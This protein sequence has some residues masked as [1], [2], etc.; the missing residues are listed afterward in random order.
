MLCSRVGSFLFS[1]T[2]QI[3]NCFGQFLAFH[4]FQQKLSD[5]FTSPL[6]FFLSQVVGVADQRRRVG[7]VGSDSRSSG[8]GRS[9]RS[10]LVLVFILVVYRSKSIIRKLSFMICF[11]LFCFDLP[12]A[13]FLERE[14]APAI[15]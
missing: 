8:S 6:F 3:P 11:F 15:A 1:N 12:D 2:I 13:F 10:E 4:T 5:L 14:L 9:R 7:G